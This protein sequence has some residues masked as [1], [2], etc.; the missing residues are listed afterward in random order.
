MGNPPYIQLS[1]D[2]FRDDQVNAYLKESFGMSGGRLNTFILFGEKS[3]RL[4]RIGGRF[5]SIIPNTLLTQEYYE[6]ARQRLAQNTWIQF[7][8]TPTAQVFTDAVV[9]NIILIAQ[10][11]AA[12]TTTASLDTTFAELTE[13]GLSSVQRVRQSEFTTNYRTSFAVPADPAFAALRTKLNSQPLKFGVLLN[14]NQAI[15]LKHD[16]AACLTN[17][18]AS[19]KHHGLNPV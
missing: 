6:E 3:R 2:E 1:M 14:I 18:P 15:A 19:S 10:P 16:R 17:K 12:P 8:V 11:T 13:L 4:T 7:L 5:G 9:E